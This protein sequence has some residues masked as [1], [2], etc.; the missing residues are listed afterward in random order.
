MRFIVLFPS[1]LLLSAF[2]PLSS[3]STLIVQAAESV[4][5]N[6]QQQSS[7]ANANDDG[8]APG[9]QGKEA[10][11]DKG[12]ED[13]LKACLSQIPANSSTGQ[14]FLAEQGCRNEHEVRSARHEAP[15]F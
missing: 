7:M 2:L 8:V 5:K 9:D 13:K 15:E 10:A 1:V 12:V 6:D 14:R 4:A 11:S 3:H